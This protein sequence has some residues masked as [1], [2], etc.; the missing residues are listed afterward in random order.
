MFDLPD[1]QILRYHWNIIFGHGRLSQLIP[2]Q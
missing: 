2:L 1:E